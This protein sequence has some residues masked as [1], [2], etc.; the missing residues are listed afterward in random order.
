MSADAKIWLEDNVSG[1]VGWKGIHDEEETSE[2][3]R[4]QQGGTLSDAVSGIERCVGKE[5][6]W[7]FRTYPNGKVGLV[8]YHG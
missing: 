4:H 5:L 2:C 1:W 3:W 8:G 6:R 7:E